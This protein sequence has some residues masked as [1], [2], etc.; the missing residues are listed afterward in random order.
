MTTRR[1]AR[2]PFLALAATVLLGQAALAQV[3]TGLSQMDQCD[4]AT[5]TIAFTNLSPTQT[6]CRIVITNTLPNPNFVYVPGSG[7][8]TPHSGA[9]V[10]FSPTAGSWDVDVLLGYA[11]AL[12][13][14]KTLTVAFDLRTTC[15]ALS[16][17]DEV[18][19]QYEDCDVPGS[20][21]HAT[22]SLSV[23]ILPGA[24][25]VTKTPAVAPAGFDDLVTWT[26]E[27][28]STGL[29]SIQNVVAWDVLG[30]GLTYVSSSPA[31]SVVGQTITWNSS[32]V[33]AFVRMPANT[34]VT[35]SLA[36]RVTACSRLENR[37][38]AR[39][40]CADGE[41]CD[42]TVTDPNG[43]GCGTATAS[44]Q[45][46]E[47]LPFLSF[48][49]PSI[50]APYCTSA[51]VH[52]P[53][54]NSGDGTAHEGILCA[55]L[56]P[57][58]VT[59]VQGGASYDGT[60][61]H[62]PDIAAGTVFDLAFDVAYSGNWC[63]GGPS[64]TS[65]F[66]LDYTNDCGIQHHAS[67]QFG[68]IG[69]SAGPSLSVS[70]TGPAVARIGSSPTY[71]VTASYSGPTS[72]GSGTMGPVTVTDQIPAGFTVSS[73]GGGVWT[74]G[75][76]GT[77][78]T[79][80]WTFAPSTPGGLD[81]SVTLEVPLLCS[82]CH[83]IVTNAITA[84]AMSCCGCALSASSSVRTSITCEA[85]YTSTFSFSPS[86]VL[87]RCGTP[88]TFTDRHTFDNDA[89]LDTVEFSDFT[90]Y[91]IKDGGL[92]YVSGTARVWI[93]GQETFAFTAIDGSGRLLVVVTDPRS[94]RNRTLTYEY[95]M[96]ATAASGTACGGSPSF[97]LW[98]Y[99]E[100]WPVGTCTESYDTASLSVEAPAM[101]VGITGVPTIQEDCAT[102]SPTVTLRRTS[103]TAAPYD[104]R[105]VV[106]GNPYVLAALALGTWSGI[107]PVAGPNVGSDGS[108]YIEWLFADGFGT[109]GASA[110]LSVPI[111]V[112][113]G[114]ELLSLSAQ[115]FFDDRCSN[116]SGYNNTCSTSASAASS[117]R[118][119]G[120]LYITKTPEVFYTTVRT[121]TWRIEVYNASNGTAYNAYV[122][123]VLGSGLVYSSSSV[124][125]H[126]GSVVTRPNLDHTGAAINGA[127]FLFDQIAPGERPVITFTANLVACH[128]M[129]NVATVGW[130]CGGQACQP[131]RSDSSSV[132]VPPANLVATSYAPTPLDACQ[133]EKATI[134]VKS[135]GIAS[136]YHV[137]ATATLPAGMLYAGGAEYRV[138][139]GGWLPTGDPGGSPG[140]TLAWT[141][142]Q[143]P[144]LAVMASGVTVDIR[145]EVSVNCSFTGGAL[146][147]Q[148]GYQ[149]PCGQTFTSAVGSFYIATRTPTL[150]LTTTQVA[151][152]AGQP[153]PCGGDVTREIRVTNS[154]GSA[155]A[156]V[157]WVEDTLG[158]GFTY[159]SSTGGADGGWNSGQ[160]T[161]WE[162]LNLAA[163]A[164]ATLTLVAH[165]TS[166]PGSC[167]ALTSTVRTYW[168]CGPDGNSATPPDCRSATSSTAS[169]SGT[170]RPTVAAAVTLSPSSISACQKE[171]TFTLTLTNASSSAPAYSPDV[172]VTLPAGLSY[173]AGTTE[174]DC[175]T[176]FSPAAD[177]VQAG[178]V[179]TWY[180]AATTG[181]GNDLC[182]S[183]P[184]GGSVAV[185]FQVDASCYRTTGSAAIDLSYYDCCGA[186]QHHATSSRSIGALPPSLT[187]AVTPATAALDCGDPLNETTWTIT[188][189][190]AS[191]TT[192]A[193]FVRVEETLG[194]DL[195]RVSGGTQ[196]GTSP[197]RWGWEFGPLGPGA[198]R[199]ETFSVRLVAS[200]SDCAL[201]RRQGSVQATWGCGSFDGD[202]N[203]VEGCAGT[204]V[205]PVTATIA[206][207]DLVV[208]NLVAT[209]RGDDSYDVTA[210]VENAGQAAAGGVSVRL[211]VDATLVSST[212]TDLAVGQVYSFSAL[213]PA[214]RCGIDHAFRLVVDE[215]GGIC[216]CSEANNEAHAS[217]SCPCPALSVDKERTAVW[218]GTTNLG[219][220]AVVEPGDVIVYRFTI[221]NVGGGTAFGV[222]VTDALPA[223]LVYETAAPG[224]DGAWSVS[225]GGSGTFV[226]PDGGT[227]FTTTIGA[228]VPAGETLTATY[229]AF[230]T[231]NARNGAS[232]TNF[233]AAT[234]REGSGD[235]I[236]ESNPSL[237]DTTDSDQDDADADDTGSET[238]TPALPGLAVEKAVID[239]RRGTGSIGTSGPVEP[240]D[241][242]TYQVIVRNVGPGTAYHVDFT[243]QL[244]AGLVTETDPP[245]SPGTYEISSPHETGSLNVPDGV[246]PSFTT[247]IDRTLVG[248]AT[249]TAMYTAFVTSGIVQGQPITNVVH[250]FGE[251]GAGAPIPEENPDVPDLFPDTAPATI[252]DAKPGLS[253][254][255]VVADV[256][257]GGVTAGTSGPV[258]FGD[259]I[260]YRFT[261]RNVGLGTAYHVEVE[262]TLPTGL[263]Y[264]SA[265]SWGRGIYEVSSPYVAGDLSI[266]DGLASFASAIDA[267]IAGGGVL[268]ATYAAR[269]TNAAPAGVDLTNVASATGRDGAGTEIPDVNQ[270]V[271]DTSDDDA[272]DSDAD[273]TG[274]ASIRVGVPALVT[275]KSVASILR[276]GGDVGSTG[277][278]E[279]GDVIAYR[280]EVRNVGQAP[281]LD[282]A[283]VD[284]LP[285]GF[286]YVPGT[287]LVTWPGGG[288]VAD[289]WDVT[290]PYLDFPLGA[291]L[292]PGETLVLTFQ[293]RVAGP[294]EVGISYTNI[295]RA[296]GRDL[297]GNEI[298]ADNHAL[299]PSDGDLDDADRVALLGA[300]GPAAAPVLR[301]TAET[302]AQAGCVGPGTV[303]DRIW[304]QTDIALYA[305]YELDELG[306]LA[307]VDASSA[308]T[309]LPTWM[310]TAAELGASVSLDN[311][312]QVAAFS[313]VGVPLEWGPR[314][315][316]VARESGR[317]AKAAL[318]V[319]LA[320]YAEEAG[321]LPAERPRNERWIV[322]EL[323]GGDPRYAT[324]DRE[325]LPSGTWPV[326]EE[327]IRASAL[328]MGFLAGAREAGQLLGST[329][330]L[331]RYRG[332]VV[333]EAIANK[334]ELLDQRIAR[335]VTEGTLRIVPTACAAV[336]KDDVLGFEV[337]DETSLLFDQVSLLFGLS[338]VLTFLQE[339]QQG[340]YAHLAPFGTEYRDLAQ[341]LLLEVLQAV[342]LLHRNAPGEVA[343]TWSPTAGRG[344]APSTLLRGLLAAALERAAPFAGE[345][346][347][348][349]LREQADRL[350]SQ[351]RATG[352]VE[353]DPIGELALIRGLLAAQD[354]LGTGGWLSASERAFDHVVDASW[355]ERIG[356]FRGWEELP[357]VTPLEV[358]VAIGALREVA[359][360]SDAVRSDR[361][362]RVLSRILDGIIQDAG[363]HLAY[364]LPDGLAPI[365]G[366]AS[367]T[368]PLVVADAALGVAPV[369]Q[370][371]ICIQTPP[372]CCGC[373]GW[374]PVDEEPWYQT[375]LAMYAAFAIQENLAWA[376]DIADA[377]LASLDLYSRLGIPL[378]EGRLVESLARSGNLSRAAAT[379]ELRAKLARYAGLTEA[380]LPDPVTIPFYAASPRLPTGETLAWN[381]GTFDRTV[382]GSALGTTLLREAQE[383]F[384]LLSTRASGEVG[385]TASEAEYA[386]L[387]LASITDKLLLL[388][389]VSLEIKRSTGVAYVP[390]ALS[391]SSSPDGL[392]WEVLDS[393]SDLF[394]Q[395]SLLLGLAETYR[396]LSSPGASEALEAVPNLA[397]ASPALVL[398]LSAHVLET[399]AEAH[400]D[401][402]LGSLVNRARLR[403][404][405]WV[406]EER[407]TTTLLGLVV[408]ALDRAAN[409]FPREQA[410]KAL[411][412]LKIET[413]FLRQAVAQGLRDHYPVEP[414]EACPCGGPDLASH[415]AAIE[416]LVIGATRGLDPGD[417]ACAQGTFDLL[418]ASRWDP[419][420]DL[421]LPG[422]DLEARCY[423]PL[424]LGL[425]ASALEK[426]A[427]ASEPLRSQFIR[428][429][430]RSTFTGLANAA[431]LQLSEVLDETED[432][433]DRPFAPVLARRVCL[434]LRGAGS[435]ETGQGRDT[436]RYTVT[437]DNPTRA[438]WTSLLLEDVLPVGVTYMSADPVAQVDGSKL[439]WTF[440]RLLPGESRSYSVLGAID[441]GARPAENCAALSY[442]NAAGVP[443]PPLRACAAALAEAAA[444]RWARQASRSSSRRTRPRGRCSC[445]TSSRES[446]PSPGQ[447]SPRGTAPGPTPAR[448]SRPCSGNRVSVSRS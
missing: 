447:R 140:P 322:I 59:N 374:R 354:A 201:F 67:P 102:Y 152:A 407:A 88:V 280:L 20:P 27:I 274:I 364:A 392:R 108:A 207:P 2:T 276:G 372:L 37:L 297:L 229:S 405:R 13:V 344:P 414:D 199:S 205:G 38:D 375:D 432:E 115:A 442:A 31:G 71:R 312:L 389:E 353:D 390:H 183:V 163:G 33:A 336:F 243:D 105:I 251:D 403:D 294:V 265:S 381:P 104:V 135:T 228:T 315:A 367:E 267:T 41:E 386:L 141:E 98:T 10:T 65:L 334:L 314:V 349:L 119:T 263:L 182:S 333:A 178:Q 185:R 210:R 329:S 24:I 438:T 68:S 82:A 12:P 361:A 78:G 409:A 196:I 161:T 346:A 175:G 418:E 167:D 172:K 412:L 379:D 241:I 16:G 21:T 15:G 155:P 394:D 223:G 109:P 124:S 273:D 146:R 283:V 25:T 194:A 106:R 328:G 351:A 113:C 47:R 310:R 136:T 232:L 332:L 326:Y 272:E 43:C 417:L 235:A 46:V 308:T 97:P 39:F 189:T 181:P 436:I 424:D 324:R 48:P 186:T 419:S 164:T 433:V 226:V 230:V 420:T 116:I 177:P 211:Y 176:G 89:V 395:L 160:V 410:E 249:L 145:F 279:P 215:A 212:F 363:L 259:V 57:L 309:L 225:G 399:L 51:T 255:K 35:I 30:P 288:S 423:T 369:L 45:F 421:Y 87:E 335:P 61:F 179:L 426:L 6:A 168:G 100:I 72:C 133:N 306:A 296:T 96:Q 74:P 278:I 247:S 56:S 316:R 313:Q 411:G 358:G 339:A 18:D 138:N 289:P 397:A 253:V 348:A 380:R 224:A 92:A 385:R 190:N 408:S 81:T 107:T 90:Y 350:L 129:T 132:L 142:A 137:T 340:V 93:D 440:D 382:T 118:L 347:L 406:R 233:A 338:E 391:L 305:A 111:T 162:V 370:E 261:V 200:A 53:I 80:T 252:G 291:R 95:Q 356:F 216:E 166:G 114:G 307:R 218:R 282:V 22:D 437:V 435:G 260:V 355:D 54:T 14:G 91:V 287:A 103:A 378:E 428:E 4:Q 237:G 165:S 154:S 443:Q 231:S 413:G 269:V 83:T 427:Q 377:N 343:E 221:T 77:G 238:I 187:L 139:A 52:L 213:T 208:S 63:A 245:G 416:A 219:P 359:L 173:R 64:G 174:V 143:V 257:R 144:T 425:A 398:D 277:P 17:N 321:L 320:G 147:A 362:A 330:A 254:D 430:L 222:D 117:L 281:A 246:T 446:S 441:P 401:P 130:G 203:T 99:H 345:P 156:P 148:A 126:P 50:A 317:P 202:P 7:R 110:T 439:H 55:N 404:E 26:L 286:A 337:R 85:L 220:V 275:D 127:S 311:L 42:N 123:D 431:R 73:A 171:T 36:A 325:A 170:R 342:R 134:T 383:A 193:E 122:D 239:I 62:L 204:T 49:P 184:A 415:L 149:N 300:A 128:G 327:T 180:N 150:S 400:A 151:P 240:G 169:Y 387:L 23:E 86:S 448:T 271:G 101:S 388:D 11:Y 444:P 318:D 69:T 250:V 242:V 131:T 323:E 1:G 112:P 8:L 393:G 209:C 217:A 44:V 303:A 29:G 214:V 60:C 58:L 244:A 292:E 125:G 331:D 384:A 304:F 371:R 79:I 32:S 121:V 256:L 94:V 266:T 153:I 429:R 290:S 396:L 9:P 298:P 191:S 268:V 195:L 66:T 295:L 236:A 248:G 341:K 422:L 402:V 234:G 301:K 159:V 3:I 373:I 299:V 198:S 366:E 293:A 158:A 76:D 192:A 120:D 28:R 445:P 302:A 352:A 285:V 75:G 19:V 5:F 368:W 434:A 84:Q 197:K 70:K 360:H 40:G 284:E 157:V 262:D 357:C 264:T 227:T 270:D 34:L 188:V 258:L 319:L 365:R 376:E 206:V